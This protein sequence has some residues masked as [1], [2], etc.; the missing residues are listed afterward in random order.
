[1]ELAVEALQ[2]LVREDIALRREEAD[3]RRY[4]ERIRRHDEAERNP[5]PPVRRTMSAWDIDNHEAAVAMTYLRFPAFMAMF[6][7]VP[8]EYLQ[9]V[10]AKKSRALD[11]LTVKCPC[12]ETPELNHGEGL[13]CECGRYYLR[14]AKRVYVTDSPKR[15]REQEQDGERATSDSVD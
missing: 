1:M 14:V 9:F 6:D 2:D 5:L 8:D 7:R 3:A 4:D 11:L 15:K 10:D 12:K 13:R